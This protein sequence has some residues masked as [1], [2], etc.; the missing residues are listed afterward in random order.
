RTDNGMNFQGV[1]ASLT[2]FD[3]NGNMVPGAIISALFSTGTLLPE[4]YI[5]KWI[6]V[7]TCGVTPESTALGKLRIEE[8]IS[9][10]FYV[11]MFELREIKDCNLPEIIIGDIT[12]VKPVKKPEIL[13]RAD[14]TPVK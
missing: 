1:G 7:Q 2:L 3:A 10:E 9:G 4:N 8:K 5:N 12:E 13:R 6:Y 11:D 14:G